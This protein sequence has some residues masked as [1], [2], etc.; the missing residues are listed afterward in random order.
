[1]SYICPCEFSF[2]LTTEVRPH[3]SQALVRSP[4]LFGPTKPC[5]PSNQIPS[6][7]ASTAAFPKASISLA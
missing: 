2:I 7:P 3:R 1:M 6:I 4:I 5:S